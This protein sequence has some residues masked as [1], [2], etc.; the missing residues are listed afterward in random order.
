MSCDHEL[1]NEWARCSGK[2]ASYI[3]KTYTIRDCV[4]L[5]IKLFCILLK[6]K[7][8]QDQNYTILA[9]ICWKRSYF[10]ESF[11]PVTGLECSYGKIFIPVNEISV[12]K[13]EVLGTG[14]ARPL[15]WTHRYFYK[16]KSGESRSRKPS[17]PDWLG[18]EALNH[19]RYANRKSYNIITLK[20]HRAFQIWRI[21]DIDVKESIEII[22]GA[23]PKAGTAHKMQSIA[24][25]G[26]KW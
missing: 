15:I 16:E 22:T 8:I 2:N 3:T 18:S 19:A 12:A 4:T 25:F 10:V 20:C 21:T 1:A 9:A 13:T 17:Q 23:Q 6:W 5:L 26:K 14:P 7:R 24:H 11:V